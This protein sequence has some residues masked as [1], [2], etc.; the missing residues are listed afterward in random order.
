MNLGQAPDSGTTGGS[1][2]RHLEQAGTCPAPAECN[3]PALSVVK[4]QPRQRGT[5]QR[6]RFPLR[7]TML[8]LGEKLHVT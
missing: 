6:N 4:R 1:D 5:Q 2:R 8:A 3:L 7:H